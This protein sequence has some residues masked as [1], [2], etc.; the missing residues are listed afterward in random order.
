MSS[1]STH[2]TI[3]PKLV[4]AKHRKPDTDND[5]QHPQRR[6]SDREEALEIDNGSPPLLEQIFLLDQ[7]LP[8]DISSKQLVSTKIAKAHNPEQD[9][10]FKKP[11]K[12]CKSQH[13]RQCH[14]Y[15]FR[16]GWTLEILLWV[17]AVACIATIIVVL[18]KYNNQPLPQW[19]Y[20]ITLNTF[21]STFSTVGKAS[22]MFVVAQSLGQLKWAW[23]YTKSAPLAHFDV[24]DAASRGPIGS[25]QLLA[26]TKGK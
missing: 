14:A 2:F 17:V 6:L 12:R 15:V 1:H 9:E 10:S 8:V 3:P 4:T 23:Y 20:S 22:L 26:L 16:E 25:F 11:S 5:C 24:F 13:K 21:I 19:P 18:Q 7:P